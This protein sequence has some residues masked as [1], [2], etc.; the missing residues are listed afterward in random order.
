MRSPYNQLAHDS[1]DVE[2]DSVQTVDLENY[3]RCHYC[4]SKL[5]F[6]HDLNLMFLQVVETSQCTGCGVA[7]SP[8]KFTLH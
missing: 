3:E 4:H 5:I 2:F 1:A 7:A 8:K 6:N